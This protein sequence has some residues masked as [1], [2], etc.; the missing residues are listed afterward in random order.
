MSRMSARRR[1]RPPGGPASKSGNVKKIPALRRC[2][3]SRRAVSLGRR[4]QSLLDRGLLLDRLRLRPD[5]L[6][7]R[8]LRLADA[9]T[10][11]AL[12]EFL[13]PCRLLLIILE[14]LHEFRLLLTLA[15]RRNNRIEEDVEEGLAPLLAA[16]RRLG[17][18]RFR[19]RHVLL[20]ELLRSLLRGR[21]RFLVRGLVVEAV[22]GVHQLVQLHGA[23]VAVLGAHRQPVVA[24]HLEVGGDGQA[25]VLLVVAAGRGVVQ[26]VHD[27]LELAR[28]LR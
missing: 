6:T 3:L 18:L 23:L 11:R 9:L 16:L 17:S 27:V 10:V 1:R 26:V 12:P 25:E 22:A 5:A 8:T 19:V 2:R 7:V 15:L 4:A 13:E 24:L 28:A 21:L 14:S 20:E